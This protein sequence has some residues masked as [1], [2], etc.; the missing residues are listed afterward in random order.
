MVREDLTNM[1][2]ENM[3][4]SLFFNEPTK[5]WHFEEI[6]G[7]AGISRPQATHWLKKFT[8]GGLIKRVKLRGKMPYYV[9]DFES[10]NYQT[11]KRLFALRTLSESGLLNHLLALPK[12]QTV[13]LFGSLSRWD[14]YKDSD[15][16]LFIYGSPEGLETGRFRTRLHREIQT[17]VCR[18]KEGLKKYG[19]SLLR[20][21]AEGYLVKG[22][23]DFLRVEA[24]A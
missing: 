13:L 7:V 20:N 22:N 18:D 10:P 14:W 9:A 21:I 16:D 17:F 15:I 4:V 11:E 5:Q 6:L 12:A 19:P 3:V 2:K 23:L 8:K 1:K 24:Y